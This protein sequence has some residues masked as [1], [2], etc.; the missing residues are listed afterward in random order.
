M[1]ED[2]LD[3]LKEDQYLKL[4]V[5]FTKAALS[6]LCHYLMDFNR[7]GITRLA[8]HAVEIADATLAEL[9]KKP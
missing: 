5:E 4:R 8:E 1:D 9:N 7:S 6:G 3:K 2:M